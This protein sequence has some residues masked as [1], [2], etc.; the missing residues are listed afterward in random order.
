MSLEMVLA[1][2]W[3]YLGLM[4]RNKFCIVI[5]LQTDSPH[6]FLHCSS[7]EVASRQG[8]LVHKGKEKGYNNAEVET[9]AFLI[10]H[11]M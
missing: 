5:K 2:F 8:L 7:V 4:V 1:S 10:V 3:S 9:L 11:C 6:R